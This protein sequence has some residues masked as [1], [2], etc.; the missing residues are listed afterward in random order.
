MGVFSVFRRRWQRLAVA[1]VVF[2]MIAFSVLSHRG[3]RF[4]TPQQ[5]SEAQSEFSS[6]TP[7]I[8]KHIN[9]STVRGG[10]FWI[11]PEWLSPSTP[12]P[13]T[14]IEAA[15]LVSQL[16]NLSNSTH[17]I[18][19]TEIPLV[20]H[21]TWKNTHVDTWPDLIRDS[22]ERWMETVI[23][24]PMAY[25]L[26]NDDGIMEF[27]EEYEPE[28]IEHF[29]ALPRMV[30]KSD[31]FRIMVCKY[32]GGVYGDVDTRPLRSPATWIE[33]AD[34]EPWRDN[35]TDI[36]YNSTKPVR[37]I[38]G[39]EAD[40]PTDTDAYW[41]MGY[42]N[43]VQLTQWALAS[44][45]GHPALTW[46]IQKISGILDE[47]AS[48]HDGNLTTPEA[49]EELDYLEPL[50]FTGPDAIT[51]SLR[52]WLEDRIGLRWNALTGLHDNGKSKL[53]DDI[54]ILPITGFSPGRGVYGNMG[55]KPVTH[56]DAR[57]QHLAQ[58]SWKG[59]DLRI[60]FGKVCRTF[61]GMCRDWPKS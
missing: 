55:S 57:L 44:A 38:F 28:F 56:H 45:P 1:S 15:R 7:L 27:L 43:P 30:E 11:P 58:G 61:F 21:Q 51:V 59:F 54:M 24:T 5:Y 20:A 16:T 17:L 42:T 18:E 26:W 2:C 22:V 48:H 10:A 14:M 60:E 47:V 4:F 33:K 19:N 29:S 32:I 34:L 37:A 36:L 49:Y 25:F 9:S 23:E 12:K 53:A 41:R 6:D 40:C 39:I 3:E 50:L 31:I 52:S 13:T 46:F 35:E 8:W